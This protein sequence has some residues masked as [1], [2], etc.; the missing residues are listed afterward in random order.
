MKFQQA[1]ETLKEV[2]PILN[3]LYNA[4][5]T[6]MDWRASMEKELIL[7]QLDIILNRI[8]QK[9][10]SEPQFQGKYEYVASNGFGVKID[11]DQNIVSVDNKIYYLRTSVMVKPVDE[12]KFSFELNLMKTDTGNKLSVSSFRGKVKKEHDELAERLAFFLNRLY[13]V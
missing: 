13:L 5:E 9:V 7:Y 11:T 1:Y 3:H 6:Q 10:L 12:V 4:D 2:Y 8:I